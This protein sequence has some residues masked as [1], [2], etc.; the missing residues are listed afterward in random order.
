[1]GA[2]VGG[3]AKLVDTL[4]FERLAREVGGGKPVQSISYF[5]IRPLTT[6][7][8][9]TAEEHTH[10]ERMEF[11]FVKSRGREAYAGQEFSLILVG[12][13]FRLRVCRLNAPNS[14]PSVSG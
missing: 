9:A 7:A 13:C 6:P 12:G 11:L 8:G 2:L 10:G 3:Q 5:L 4:D 1:M 14:V